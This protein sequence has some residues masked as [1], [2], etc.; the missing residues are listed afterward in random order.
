[1]SHTSQAGISNPLPKEPF[2]DRFYYLAQE[3]AHLP[4]L[5]KLAKPINDDGPQTASEEVAKGK[6]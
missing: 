1:M 2:P 3:K 5:Q 4:I 6:K